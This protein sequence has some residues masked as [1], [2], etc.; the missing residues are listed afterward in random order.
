MYKGYR[1]ELVSRFT[2]ASVDR[3]CGANTYH[4]S[5]DRPVAMLQLCAMTGV[6]EPATS[7][8]PDMAYT[9]PSALTAPSRASSPGTSAIEICQ[10]NP[11]G[12]N[13][14]SSPRPRY[15][16]MLYWMAGPVAPAG[17]A[18]K[19]ARNHSITMSARMMLPTR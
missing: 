8:D 16:A 3:H 7:C 19:L 5:S 6:R 10:L 9:V 13:S 11:N 15:P 12:A 17:G 4:A 14:H 18:G 1:Q 2:T